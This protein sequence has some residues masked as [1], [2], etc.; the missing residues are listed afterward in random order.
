MLKNT[1]F[2]A[3]SLFVSISSAGNFPD[4]MAELYCT[5]QGHSEEQCLNI[6]M[7][8]AY[9]LNK[10]SLLECR[11]LTGTE[12][13]KRASRTSQEC[14]GKNL[15]TGLCYQDGHTTSECT[16]ITAAKLI[17]KSAGR[18]FE[19]CAQASAP[20]VLCSTL[21]YTPKQCA[22]IKAAEVLCLDIRKDFSFCKGIKLDEIP[23]VKKGFTKDQMKNG[24][25]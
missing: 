10:F 17:C 3:I 1:L 15:I 16:K 13:C 25:E 22:D 6:S 4:T 23:C 18:T 21:G 12:L 11:Q 14:A 2:I 20:E 8:N 24:C 5:K 9:C 7:E 19:D